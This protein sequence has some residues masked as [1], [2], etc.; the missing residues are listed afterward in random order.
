MTT[1]YIWYL[2]VA[3]YIRLAKCLV[4][5]LLFSALLLV[6]FTTCLAQAT[7]ASRLLLASTRHLVPRNA[8]KLEILYRHD[9]VKFDE[10]E[11]L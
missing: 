5:K 11:Y 10:L 7:A 3:E 8:K 9:D 4:I 2:V 6:H 1:E